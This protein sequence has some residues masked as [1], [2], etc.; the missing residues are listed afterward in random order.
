M[1]VIDFALYGLVIAKGLLLNTSMRLRELVNERAQDQID[2]ESLATSI[3][4]Y[5]Q[6]GGQSASVGKITGTVGPLKNIKIKL[7]SKMPAAQGLSLAA[8]AAYDP[9]TRAIIVPRVDKDL[10]SELVH[11][12]RHA[13][14][15]ISS[16][17]KFLQGK[18]TITPKSTAS[19]TKSYLSVPYEINA[20]FSQA[21]HAIVKDLS[22]KN[23]SRNDIIQAIKVELLARDILQFY[24]N[25]MNDPEYRRL[26]SRALSYLEKRL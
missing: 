7:V 21:V 5:L 10:S 23:P 2:I 3:S 16:D 17:G 22:G 25:R 14:D 6:S 11:E 24:P 26:F 20:R 8:D 12:L 1:L 9:D 18:K 4:Q 15:D 13:L 19:A